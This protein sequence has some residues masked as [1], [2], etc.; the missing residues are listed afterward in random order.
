MQDKK[1]REIKNRFDKIIESDVA[2]VRNR[3]SGHGGGSTEKIVSEHLATYVINL[4]A[5]NLVFIVECDNE[6]TANK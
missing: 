2:P 5:S 6:Y 1:F 4:T 3:R